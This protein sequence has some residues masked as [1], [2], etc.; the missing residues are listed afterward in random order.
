MMQEFE[1]HQKKEREKLIFSV[2]EK[3]ATENGVDPARVELDKKWL[4][5]TA[6][7]TTGKLTTKTEQLIISKVIEIKNHQEQIEQNINLVKSYAEAKGLEPGSWI[8]LVKGGK[9]AA[10]LFPKIDEV[11]AQKLEEEKEELEK[12][13]QIIKQQAKPHLPN[14]VEMQK[15]IRETEV[16]NEP[17]YSFDLKITGTLK[18]L[19]K[20][21]K[22]IEDI[23]VE[24][25]VVMEE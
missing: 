12:T 8:I 19:S 24:Y 5:T 14:A 15:I 9:T 17:L 1:T 20:I 11:S 25:S 22:T 21:K 6:F 23:G 4:N 2:I 18:Q 7:T 10:Q 16:V 3:I 13:E